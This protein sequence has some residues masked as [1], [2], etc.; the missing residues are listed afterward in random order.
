MTQHKPT[1]LGSVDWEQEG[2]G[3]FIEALSQFYLYT[4]GN[5]T[6]RTLRPLIVY[7]LRVGADTRMAAGM[8]GSGGSLGYAQ[9]QFDDD[10][11]AYAN[12]LVG[13]RTVVDELYES[14]PDAPSQRLAEQVVGPLLMGMYPGDDLRKIPDAANTVIQARQVEVGKR[15]MDDAWDKLIDDLKDRSTDTATAAT[16]GLG[17]LVGLIGALWLRRS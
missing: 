16:L 1:A 12:R 11:Q 7:L 3:P 13:Y 4:P 2:T 6:P 10:W 17:L 5:A 8:P 15:A 14:D 9:E